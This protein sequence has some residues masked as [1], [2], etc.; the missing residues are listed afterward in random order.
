[1]AVNCP[2]HSR[3]GYTVEAGPTGAEAGGLW[4]ARGQPRHVHQEWH[5]PQLPLQRRQLG[6]CWGMRP[7]WSG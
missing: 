6:P 3:G 2:L 1:M 7:C 5:A 4:C